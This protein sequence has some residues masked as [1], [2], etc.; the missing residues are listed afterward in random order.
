MVFLYA[1]TVFANIVIKSCCSE[2]DLY[3]LVIV[4]I[5][6]NENQ[7][8]FLQ[9]VWEKDFSAPEIHFCKMSQL[10][11]IFVWLDIIITCIKYLM[12]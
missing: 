4:Q 7:A 8:L 5:C 12:A 2:D 11:I 6:H 3:P 1:S 9:R 10:L